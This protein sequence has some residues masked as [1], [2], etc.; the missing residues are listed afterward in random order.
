MDELTDDGEQE[1]EED[2]EPVGNDEIEVGE[3]I[4]NDE[5]EKVELVVDKNVEAFNGTT[6]ENSSFKT[7]VEVLKEIRNEKIDKASL[8]Y[9]T[10]TY[11]VEIKSCPA[12]MGNTIA[13]ILAHRSDSLDVLLEYI[14]AY[15]H[16]ITEDTATMLLNVVSIVSAD[17]AALGDPH[18]IVS[19]YSIVKNYGSSNP[20]PIYN[21]GGRNGSGS[22]GSS[23]G[24]PK[25]D[26]EGNIIA[27]TSIQNYE[28]DGTNPPN[29][30]GNINI[31][32]WNNNIVQAQNV[33]I[34]YAQSIDSFLKS[35][36]T[37]IATEW[38][39]VAI[40]NT[41]KL[42][43]YRTN[44]SGQIIRNQ[45]IQIGNNIYYLDHNGIMVTGEHT[46]NGKVCNFDT[47]I[48]TTEGRF[49]Y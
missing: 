7:I 22:G 8:G 10:D 37:P 39:G 15:S 13:L 17:I 49:L 36:N 11:A 29:L 27:P 12:V 32:I 47:T 35:D 43:W 26:L 21:G 18:F 30:T 45:F 42:V 4:K 31:A 6:D 14:N 16:I 46:I 48:G 20:K 3:H 33:D 44:A 23:V 24:M 38:I 28:Y 34:H 2:E 1:I 19:Y 9:D 5:P 25:Y 41:S 40:E